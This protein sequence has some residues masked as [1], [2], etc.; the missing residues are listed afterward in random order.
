MQIQ[1]EFD[2]HAV[3]HSSFNTIKDHI[4]KKQW[5]DEEYVKVRNMLY[6]WKSEAFS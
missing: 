3:F 4:K 5:L 2:T 6:Y 1:N